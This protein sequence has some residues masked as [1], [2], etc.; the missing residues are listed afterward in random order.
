M[1]LNCGIYQIRNIVTNVCYAGQSIH[2]KERP[3]QHWSKLKNNK[4]KNSHLQNSY[5]K[6]GKEFFVFEI[7]IYCRQKELTKYEQLFCDIDKTHGLSYNIRDCVDSNKGIKRSLETKKLM[8]ENHVRLSGKDHP[9]FGKHHSDETI[10]KISN[11]L[12]G[13]YVGKK[14]HMWGKHL[15]EKTKGKISKNSAR[16]SGEDAPMWGKRGKDSPNFGKHHSEETKEK[17]RKAKKGQKHSEETK[18]KIS[19]N[20][21]GMLGK[22]HSEETKKKISEANSGK[23]NYKIF[24][25]EIVLEI[26]ELLNNG[27]PVV[28]ILKEI[29]ISMSTVYRIKNG[30]Y[31]DIYDL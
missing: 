9:N 18:R 12:K 15:S 23:N 24:K 11:T 6:Y 10:K 1:D 25:E 31:N 16:L 4:H 7:L 5:N 13:K 8:S 30:F 17:M 27:I 22:V 3:G 14:N 29:D 20:H 26:L 28:K 19:E 2:L 21:V